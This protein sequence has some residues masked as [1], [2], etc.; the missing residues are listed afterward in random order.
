MAEK[1]ARLQRLM[2]LQNDISKEINESYLNKVVEVL[3]EGTS[4]TN[5]DMLTGKTDGNKT[6]IFPGSDLL[7]GK[8]V[9]VKITEPQT[10]I[11]KGELEEK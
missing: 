8:I 1:K 3:V 9:S 5:S 6:V 7:I 4:K 10:W 2:D 11:L